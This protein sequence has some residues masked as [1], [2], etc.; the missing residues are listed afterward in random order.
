[1]SA[2]MPSGPVSQHAG[3]ESCK[4]SPHSLLGDGDLSIFEGHG[5]EGHLEDKLKGD[6]EVPD[7]AWRQQYAALPAKTRGRAKT[8][9][10][11]LGRS[12]GL[13]KGATAADG[14]HDS[15]G[16]RRRSAATAAGLCSDCSGG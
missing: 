2:R 4:I 5:Y 3:R 9:A 6:L 8:A 7:D 11:G 16:Q 13:P 10:G 14:G 12:R 15:G 1:M